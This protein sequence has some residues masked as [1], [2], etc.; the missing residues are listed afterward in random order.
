MEMTLLLFKFVSLF[1]IKADI[2][3]DAAIEST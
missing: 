1:I 3:I 2:V